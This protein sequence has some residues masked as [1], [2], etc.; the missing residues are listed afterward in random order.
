[1]PA[2]DVVHAEVFVWTSDVERQ[3]SEQGFSHVPVLQSGLRYAVSEG[4][5]RAS[6]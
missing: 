4:C 2:G 1:M 6:E 3:W 5:G